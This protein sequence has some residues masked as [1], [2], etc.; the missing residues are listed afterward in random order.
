MKSVP[1]D[2]DQFIAE[3]LNVSDDV[4]GHLSEREAK[5]LALLAACPTTQGEVL[6]IGSFKGKSTIILAKSAALAGRPRVVAVDPLTSPAIT[7]AD[8]EASGWEDF[9]PNLKAAGVDQFVEF[10]QTYSSELAKVWD[11]PIRLLWIDGDHTYAGVKSDFDLFSPFLADGAIIAMHDV[12]HEFEGCIRVFLEDI[13]LSPHFGP[14]G[15][16]GSIGWSQ[17]FADASVSNKYKQQKMKLYQR[18]S[19]LIPY[20]AFNNKLKDWAK[21]KY[22]F[23]R[24][25]VPHSEVNPADWLSEVVFIE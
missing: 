12:L 18:L 19:R 11:R 21:R 1:E 8:L 17:Y 14:V 22:K 4:G 5:F 3:V 20:V 16:C 24:W 10:H 15:F 13:L 9:R 25:R 7:D 23:L 6:E 2:F